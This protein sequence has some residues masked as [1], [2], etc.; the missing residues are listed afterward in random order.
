[1][2]QTAEVADQEPARPRWPEGLAALRYRNFAL[3]FTGALLS[4]SGAWMQI[5]A[6]PYVVLQLTD[7]A[8]AVSLVSFFLFVPILVMGPLG[9]TL[10][11][12]F[13][14]R[15]LLL[16]SHVGQ[17]V[18]AL[19]LGLV[20]VAGSRS[21]AEDSSGRPSPRLSGWPLIETP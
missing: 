11:D 18:L 4:N 10:A 9:G 2:A 19:A 5:I 1:M 8:V 15:R 17:A 12:R 20:W 6:V 3:F 14:R 7:S 21:G 13:D 16:W